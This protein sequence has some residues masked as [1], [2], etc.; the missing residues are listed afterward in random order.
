MKKLIIGAFSVLF[1]ATGC[2][3]DLKKLNVNPQAPSTI[4]MNFLMTSAQLGTASGG[5][6]GDNR[7]IDWRTNIG[8]CAHAIQHIANTGASIAPGD[9]YNQDNGETNA[10]PWDFL[11]ND[12]LQ[13]LAEILRQTG[14]GGFEE[15]RS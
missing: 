10:A 15:G 12:V 1:F 11:Y 4:D 13:N 5:S 3:E 9:K 7:Y 6:R 8:M 2:E 14:P